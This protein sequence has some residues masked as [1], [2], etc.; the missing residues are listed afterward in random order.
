MEIEVRMEEAFLDEDKAEL[1]E[2]LEAAK[3][4]AHG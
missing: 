4:P 1:D 3:R 2:M